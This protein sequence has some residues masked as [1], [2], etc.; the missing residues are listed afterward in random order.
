LLLFSIVPVS[1]LAKKDGELS[2]HVKSGILF[3]KSELRSDK[4]SPYAE[5]RNTL[6]LCIGGS[7]NMVIKRHFLVTGGLDFGYENYTAN[8]NYPFESLGFFEPAFKGSKYKQKAVIP[9]SQISLN[10]GCRF[11]QFRKLLPEIKFG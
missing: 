2:L 8:I 1:G 4:G 11:S 6:Q 5:L 3:N 9:Y 10:I 7:Y